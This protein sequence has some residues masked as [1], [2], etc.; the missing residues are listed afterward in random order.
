MTTVKHAVLAFLLSGIFLSMLSA[1]VF[2]W[3]G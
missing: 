3:G 2:S 1:T